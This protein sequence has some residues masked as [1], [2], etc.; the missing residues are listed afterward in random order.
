[1]YCLL[2]Q[3]QLNTLE[4]QTGIWRTEVWPNQ[5]AE[6]T[7]ERENSSSSSAEPS[8]QPWRASLKMQLPHLGAVDIAI[9][10]AG[11][12]PRI[13]IRTGELHAE[14]SLTA[15]R[16]TLVDSLVGAGFVGEAIAI[17]HDAA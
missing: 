4:S 16:A 13:G 9:Y 2:W 12:R 7:I 10:L 5:I 17:N 15:A 1:M 14:E 11:D 8:Q 6:L 3:H